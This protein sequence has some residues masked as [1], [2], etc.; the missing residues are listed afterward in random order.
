MS[1][2]AKHIAD[3]S[4]EP[5]TVISFPDALSRERAL[6][7]RVSDANSAAQ[8]F[9]WRTE[10]ALVVPRGMPARVNFQEAA[11]A[12]GRQGWPVYE[13]D[14]GGDVTP[15]LPGVVNVSMV[16]RTEEAACSIQRSYRRLTD[17]ISDFLR[18]NL[19]L[20][21]TLSSVPGSFCDGA[22]NIVAE[23][24]KLGGTAQRW[25]LRRG[26]NGTQGANILAHVAIL[27]SMDI[28]PAIRSINEFY[29]RCAIAKRVDAAKHITL[30]AAL[31]G[32][33]PPTDEIAAGIACH[34]ASRQL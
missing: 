32:N 5:N 27:C 16:F 15:Q 2:R 14:T 29:A 17:P 13:R 18:L 25:Q 26:S 33:C 12:L 30:A 4:F 24:R 19:G 8:F 9:V 23:D 21:T 20:R 3:S 6:L 28:E 31:N 7:A 11:A 1:A 22:Y 10:R 34:L